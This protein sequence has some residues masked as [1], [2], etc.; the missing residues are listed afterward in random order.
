[1]D[2]PTPE[3]KDIGRQNFHAAIGH[4][5]R[6]FLKESLTAAVV[7]GGSLG[8]FYYGYGKS[9][10]EPV[11]VGVVGTGDQGS[12]LM[13]ACNPEF[14]QVKA[15]AD[16]RPYNIHR[17]F[18]GDW[19]SEAAL[20]A[21]PGLMKVYGWESEEEARRHVQVYGD[22][23]ELL[24]HADDDGL[25]MIIVG[26]PLHLHASATI[27]AM[28]RGLHVLCEKL[29]AQTVYACKEMCR[30]A[31]ETGLLLAV[32]HQRHYNILYENAV[33]TI[34]RGLI[35]ELAFIR[36]QWHRGNVPG[37]DSWQPPMPEAIKPDDPLAGDLERGLQ[38]WQG[39]LERE[40]QTGGDVIT[41]RNRVAQRQAQ[42][43]DEAVKDIAAQFG[44]EDGAIKD[45][46]GNVVYERPAAEELIRWRLWERTGGGLMAEL[47]SHQLDAA[48]IFISAVHDGVKQLPLS[49][50]ASAN[51]PLFPPDRDVE[52]QIY[53]IIEFP[54]PGFNPDDPHDNR[55]RIGVQYS[56]VNGNGFGGYGEVVCGTNGTLILETELD[57]MLYKDADV[58][59]RVGVRD[60]DDLILDTQASP[61]QEAAVAAAATA[62]VS[63]GYREQI[64]H[65]AWCIRNPAPENQPRCGPEVALADAV[66]ALVTNQAAHEE[67]RIDFEKEWFE[68]DSDA[69][70]E[71]VSP[72]LSRYD[73]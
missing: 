68:I 43:A 51:R 33:D 49:V 17:A 47:G 60:D 1:M 24:E 40:E 42:I 71:G 57:V 32:G 41:W 30:A 48:S 11:R 31:N 28:R 46:A 23:R 62:R 7:A 14:V 19:Y 38:S 4:T 70:P 25:E 69:T 67:R 5:R 8:A 34:R 12:V 44:Y 39:R 73:A 45:A 50:V 6:D 58:S 53:C 18:H 72:D 52:D 59:S 66:M 13:G 37:R 27:A 29:M 55:K 35:G 56:S 16:I 20:E 3:Q 54:A 64:E 9:V 10:A 21:R 61:G 36:A 15:I 2:N 63:R 65:L 26:L 22:Y